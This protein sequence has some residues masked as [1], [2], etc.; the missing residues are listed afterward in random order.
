MKALLFFILFVCQAYS[1]SIEKISELRVL[2]IEEEILLLSSKENELNFNYKSFT[3]NYY[4]FVETL[5]KEELIELFVFIAGRIRGIYSEI[6]SMKHEG[7]KIEEI[8]NKKRKEN[9]I[10]TSLGFI[11]E[12]VLKSTDK[13]LFVF[14]DSIN[15]KEFESSKK[16]IKESE[17]SKK[18]SNLVKLYCSF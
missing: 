6:D 15:K 9:S 2:T 18:F 5:N 11:E 16:I 10:V 7:E 1:C 14:I 8:V 12:I 3:K 17:Q 4:E 13:N